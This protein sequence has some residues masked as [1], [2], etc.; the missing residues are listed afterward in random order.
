MGKF[1]NLKSEKIFKVF[2]ISDRDAPLVTIA[3]HD[4]VVRWYQDS[5]VGED[6]INQDKAFC[7]LM[8]TRLE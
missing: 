5:L 4:S 7:D 6:F 3:D 8:L 1:I 2:G